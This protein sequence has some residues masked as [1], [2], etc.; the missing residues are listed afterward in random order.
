MTTERTAEADLL[1]FTGEQLGA[2]GYTV[3][4]EPP[5]SA[6]PTALRDLKPDAIAIG[7]R[8]FL[9]IEVTREGG[10]SAERVHSL[11]RA[12]LDA[13]EWQLY[14]VFDSSVS[15]ALQISMIDDI[16]S[17]IEKIPLVAADDSR[18]ALLMCWAALEALSRAIAPSN[19]SRP[20]TPSRIV[21]W[22]AT[23]PYIA[24]GEAHFLRGMANKRNQFIHGQLSTSVVTADIERFVTILQ[25]LLV[26]AQRQDA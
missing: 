21:E 11:R 8:P 26:V 1:S 10:R 17:M 16:A 7:R 18:A 19:F 25:A 20:Q 14:L 12:L 24:A 5:R 3:V 13:P 15:K 4:F 6:L 23:E 9:L 22:L 2:S